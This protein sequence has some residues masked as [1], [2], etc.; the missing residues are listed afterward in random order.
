M[1]V[2]N[3]LAAPKWS[4][5]A[6]RPTIATMIPTYKP[7]AMSASRGGIGGSGRDAREVNRR[8]RAG[9]F[10]GRRWVGCCV[11]RLA[12][13]RLEVAF[14]I[15]RRGVFDISSAYVVYGIG[16]QITVCLVS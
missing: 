5:A 12:V 9:R 11:S 1:I 15:V 8:V 13:C 4:M 3:V 6:N 10:G 14:I 2:P 16:C 7:V